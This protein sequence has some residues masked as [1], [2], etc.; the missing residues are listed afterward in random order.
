MEKASHIMRGFL[1]AVRL[2]T[3]FLVIPA[4]ACRLPACWQAG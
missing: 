1:V 2:L 4:P 3:P